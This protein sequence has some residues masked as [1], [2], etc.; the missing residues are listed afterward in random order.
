MIDD[1]GN[2]RITDFGVAALAEELRGEHLYAGTPAYMSP[3]QFAGKEL[4]TRSDIYSLGLVLY[5]LFT[6]KRAFDVT[7]LQDLRRVRESGE[8]PTSPSSHVKDLDPSIER[9]IL[10]CLEKDPQK[11]PASALQVAAALPGG[12]PLAAALAIGETPS[13][14]MV[15]AA[16]KEGTLRPALAVS[17]LV[18]LLA[19]I[20]LA[21]LI[22]NRS[23]LHSRVPLEKSSEVLRER[24]SELVRK[25]GYTDRP[26]DH[27]YGFLLHSEYLRYVRE[28]DQS[29]NR[30]DRLRSGQPAAVSFWYRQ[31]PHYIVPQRSLNYQLVTASDPPVIL[32]GMSSVFLDSHGRLLRFEFVPEQ[33]EEQPTISTEP[34]WSSLFIEAGLDPAAFTPTDSK[35][36]PPANSDVHRAWQGVYPASPEIPIRVEA[37]SFRGRPIYFQIIEPW[38]IAERTRDVGARLP[39]EASWAPTWAAQ[40][41]RMILIV[42]IVTL[43]VLLARHNLRSG[44]GDRRGAFRLAAFAF[45]LGQVSWLIGFSHVPTQAEFDSFFRSLVGW[46]FTAILLWLLYISLEPYVRR[47]WPH[48]LISWSRLLAGEWRD[49]FVGRDILIG[50]LCGVA[51]GLLIMSSKVLPGWFQLPEPTPYNIILSRL[52]GT[53]TAV[54]GFLSQDIILA[55]TL[56]LGFLFLL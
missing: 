28:N 10:R 23:M 38:T 42:A 18:A 12:D 22:S 4:T 55:L 43:G 32:S 6:G 31:S 29:P 39:Y 15:A 53:R 2:A 41:F 8:S 20:A 46:S 21:I 27:A 5:E 25:M 54:S 52:L 11:R 44:R 33:I 30:W 35:W 36:V 1:A 37:A 3:E 26:V 7:Q 16:P 13:P 51:S 17:F 56:G 14:E 47:R 24:A 9:V 40:I 34:D 45:M 19:G 48:R 50:G 49:P